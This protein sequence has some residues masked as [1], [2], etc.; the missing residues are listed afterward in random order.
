[1]TDFLLPTWHTAWVL[2][3]AVKDVP[4]AQVLKDE[5]KTVKHN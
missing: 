5:E 3:N 2:L 4:Y 1:M